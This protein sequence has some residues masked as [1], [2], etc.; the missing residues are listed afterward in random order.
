MCVLGV[1]LVTYQDGLPRNY[2]QAKA[3]EEQ[4]HIDRVIDI[5]VERWVAVEKMLGRRCVSGVS[6][7]S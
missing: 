2:A 1:T 5:Q 3:L 4:V 6:M 7:S